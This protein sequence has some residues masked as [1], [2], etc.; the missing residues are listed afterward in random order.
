[1]NKTE[2]LKLFISYSH[3]DKKYISEFIKHINPLKTN[4][5]ISEWYDRKINAGQNYQE[6]IDINLGD[7]AIICLM[8]SA[9]FLNSKACL[10]E[11]MMQWN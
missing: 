9:N 3:D 10:K 7:S 8:I 1:M 4:G 11:K 2:R 5:N 6:K